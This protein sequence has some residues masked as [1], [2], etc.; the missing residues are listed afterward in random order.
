MTIRQGGDAN[1]KSLLVTGGPNIALAYPSSVQSQSLLVAVVIAYSTSGTDQS[2][3][4][5]TVSDSLNAGNW[6]EVVA[7]NHSWSGTFSARMYYK[8]NSAAGACTVTAAYSADPYKR[9]IMLYEVT[10]I[11]TAAALEDFDL[12]QGVSSSPSCGSVT[13]AGAAFILSAIFNGNGYAAFATT[14]GWAD[15]GDYLRLFGDTRVADR[16]EAAGGTF[17]GDFTQSGSVQYA[18]FIA[19]FKAAAGGGPSA[20]ALKRKLLLGVG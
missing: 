14:S 11:D 4:T 2:G 13:T 18:G 1:T 19:A 17:T 12:A 7:T 3:I 20:S 8:Q 5:I 16:E 6:T 9:G 10:G 15:R